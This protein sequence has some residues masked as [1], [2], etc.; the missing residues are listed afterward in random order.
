MNGI[1]F[2][3]SCEIPVTKLHWPSKP[4]S[5]GA[6]PVARPPAWQPDVG[7]RTFT[8][9]GEPFQFVGRPSGVYGI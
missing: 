8:P 2:P 5:L 4:D 7:L 9:V 6:R 1:C 3:Q